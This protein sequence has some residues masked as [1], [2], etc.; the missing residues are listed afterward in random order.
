MSP[1]YQGEYDLLGLEQRVEVYWDSAGV[2][3]I[4]G[5]VIK[6]VILASGFITAQE[7][8][9]QM[10]MMRRLAKGRLSEMFGE[11]TL[12]IDMLFR[13]IAIDSITRRNYENI[14][15]DS[16]LWLQKYA[17]GI[18]NYIRIAEDDL[19][20]EFLLMNIRPELWTPQ[21]CLLQNRLMAWILN[22]NWKAD[23]LYWQLYSTLPREKFQEIWPRLMDYP[24]IIENPEAFKILSKLTH[25]YD[26]IGEILNFQQLYS[27]SNN[28]VIS[29]EKTQ[30]G[31]ALLANDPHLNLQI[32]SI[33]FEM[34]LKTADV[35]VAGFALP[36]S[37]GIIIGRNSR[38]AW[39]V[40]NGMIDDSDYFIERIDTLKKYYYQD[41]VPVPL[42]VQSHRISVK[43]QMD[44]YFDIY[45][46]NN[47]P[48]FNSIF[49]KLKLSNFISFRW[50]GWEISDELSTFIKLSRAETWEDFREAFRSYA[51]PAQNFVYSDII[52]NI[53]YLLSGRIPIRTYQSG[54]IP[55]TAFESQNRW[56]G[57]ISFQ[58]MPNLYNPVDGSIVTA[59]NPVMKS[60]P[61][62]LSELWEPPYRALRIK[63]M[64]AE[65][66]KVSVSD[67]KKF[68]TDVFNLL[69]QEI[70]PVVISHLKSK[71]LEDPIKNDIL[72]L[73]RNWNFKMDLDKIPPAVYEVLQHFLVRNI[74]TD[75]MGSEL[76]NLFTDLP[77]FYIRIFVQIFKTNVSEW[78]DDVTTTR[79][80]T[81]AEIIV[82]SFDQ[83]IEYLRRLLGDD[84][85]DWRWRDL[86]KVNFQHVLG[87][88]A[89]TRQIF[90]RGPFPFSGDG[91]TVN[92]GIY[93]YA[94]PFRVSGGASLRFLVDWGETRSYWSIIPGGNSGNFL[95]EYYD[96]QIGLWRRGALKKVSMDNFETGNKIILN[97]IHK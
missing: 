82:R 34:H 90:N 35:D 51:L 4:Q 75:E 30:N 32:P 78:F 28:W 46:T 84:L 40:T 26:Q 12:E 39:G 29:P 58:Q 54:L 59:N 6:D 27:G 8:L 91:T 10:E 65:A 19:P 16:K 57:W 45:S 93:R 36:G 68:Q 1:D 47:G 63:Q 37:P 87:K 15:T 44:F 70:V 11:A 49:P 18:N 41:E 61:F 5:D 76:F 64:I 17:E 89:L 69:A 3:H 31:H 77:N 53:G 33:W 24:D 96:N 83:S 21:D 74:F 42:Q 50:V 67:T 95:S 71:N 80:E 73:L 2:V 25:L 56:K 14:S 94:E 7:R 52:G 86:N 55:Q 85:S 22:F 66:D 48:V 81:K 38:I 62:Y 60:Y 23:L 92:A 79:R 20:I 97:P 9:W 13:T 72:V 43:D 88:V